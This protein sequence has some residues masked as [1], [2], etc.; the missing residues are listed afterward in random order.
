MKRT[1]PRKTF[2]KDRSKENKRRY[3]KQRNYCVSR[4]RMTKKDYY[5]NLDIKKETDSK[6]FQRTIKAVPFR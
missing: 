2:L 6:A 1:R 5:S 3:S 4:I